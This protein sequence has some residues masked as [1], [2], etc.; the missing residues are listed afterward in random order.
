[1]NSFI[2]RSQ[3]IITLNIADLLKMTAALCQKLFLRYFLTL[4]F[5]FLSN[6]LD[7]NHSLSFCQAPCPLVSS[8]RMQED[9]HSHSLSLLAIQKGKNIPWPNYICY[10]CITII[11][12]RNGKV[13]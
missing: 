11:S 12:E 10:S 6:M 3:R 5:V 9:L 2:L 1:M 4:H 13:K 8:R 7:E